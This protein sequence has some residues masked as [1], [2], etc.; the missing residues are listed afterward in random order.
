MIQEYHKVNRKINHNKILNYPFFNLINI[1]LVNSLII[2]NIQSLKSLQLITIMM[3]KI[4]PIEEYLSIKRETK[5]LKMILYQKLI[6]I[7]SKIMSKSVRFCFYSIFWP[8]SLQ[9][10]GNGIYMLLL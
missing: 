7:I 4:S 5:G 1:T 2:L 10:V 8:N 6:S 3:R 9:L